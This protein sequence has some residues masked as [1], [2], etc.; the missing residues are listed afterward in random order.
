LNVE[1]ERVI[2]LQRIDSAS[3]DATRRLAD[4]T[5]RQKAFD[6]RLEVA[7]AQVTAAKQRLAEN[8]EARRA[9]E[10]DLAVHQGRLSKFR[11]QAM[12]VKTN[13]EYHAIQKEITFAQGEIQTLEGTILE[14]MID[15]DDLATEAKRAE[16][17]LAA[18]QTGVETE[19]R[20]MSAEYAELKAALERLAGERVALAAT[21]DER[22]LRVFEGIA[23]RRNG[24]GVAEARDGICTICH[25]RLRPQVFNNVLANSE[26]IQC[27]ICQRILYHVPPAPASQPETSA[28]PS[29]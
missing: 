12:A 5:E 29:V 10:K 20:A 15:A 6:D 17:S 2:R 27:D 13:Q 7:R 24:V 18:E 8:Q 21:L 28:E 3:H 16:A 1:L 26:I 9:I 23:R 19:R 14:R 22:V 25:V 4:E 11:E